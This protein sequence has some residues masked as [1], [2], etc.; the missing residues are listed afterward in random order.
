MSAGNRDVNLTDGDLFKPLLLLSAPIVASQLMQVVYN[1]ADTFWVG[2][3]GSGA[4][5]AVS[6]AFPLVFLLISLGTGFSIAG[7]ALVSQNKGAGNHDRVNHVAGQTITF[8]MLASL[9]FAVIG[10][11]AA[12]T[13]VSLIGATP[14]SQVYR[15]TVEFTQ[16]TFV[17][18]FFMSG[19]FM[20][21]ALLR[22]W[23]DTKTPM[24]LIA[25]GVTLNIILDPFFYGFTDN[26]LLNA[27]GLGGLETTLLNLTG[28]TGFG[29]QG[30][31]IATVLSRGVGA[32]IGL[33]ILFSGRVGIHL[34]RDNITPDPKTIKKIVRIGAPASVDMSMR[35][36]GITFLTAI[37]SMAGNPAVAAFG[38]GN[39]LNSLVFLPSI[40][41]AQGTTTAVGQNLGADKPDRS[42]RAVYYA[43]GTLAIVLAGVS[44][45]AWYFAEPIVGVFVGDSE[46][47]AQVIRIGAQYLR[48][49]G[50]TFLFLG[51]FR[52]VT[53]AFRGA[54]DTTTAMVFTILSLWVFRIP[55]AYYLLE[56][57][58]M[59][60]TGVWYAIAFSNTVTAILAFVWFRRGA[61][62]SNE[63]DD[64]KQPSPAD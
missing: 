41:L 10:Y 9:I 61:W 60:A 3:I 1:L 39:R 53:S 32:V 50:P 11:F 63:L 51:V 17:G 20:F 27:L 64:V 40:G 30:A 44:V 19:F 31:A 37:V 58:G 22:G 43:S 7:T 28:F 59:G 15:W 25:F 34:S 26:L 14:G 12:P 33:T 46:T 42:E 5:S 55:V 48:I 2:Q 24:Y 18:V 54:G 29:V 21:Q 13:L 56:V 38:I 57:N 62:K 8:T 35:A 23:G 36:L 52:V 49:I 45:I 47:R 4:V 16:T 6:Y